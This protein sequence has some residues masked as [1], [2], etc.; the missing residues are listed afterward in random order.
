VTVLDQSLGE[1][2]QTLVENGMIQEMVNFDNPLFEPSLEFIAIS[3]VYASKSNEP[4]GIC[5]EGSGFHASKDP[6][7]TSI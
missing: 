4:E 3:I 1:K 7:Q 5:S 6:F 2:F